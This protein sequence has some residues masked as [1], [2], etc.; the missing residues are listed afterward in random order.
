M[1]LKNII[2]GFL[3]NKE[4]NGETQLCEIMSK[5]GSD[6][7]KGNHNYTTLYTKIFSN[8]INEPINLFE[9]GLGTNNL[10]IDSNMGIDGKPGAS[11][12]GW[13]EFFPKGNI[14][15][16]DIDKRILFNSDRINTYYCDQC[17][18]D[19][20]KEMFNCCELKNVEFDI[21]IEDGLHKFDANYT[22]LTNSINRLK[23]GGIYVIEDLTE[24][25]IY[26]FNNILTILENKYSCRYISIV[27]IPSSHNKSDNNL[28]IC[29]V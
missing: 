22:F 23:K 17:S 25:T 7:G 18:P 26:K 3:I 12:F 1:D 24:E 27:K 2:E 19:L 6:K 11:L 28:L 9:L 16:A 20:I 4:Y 10:D 29:Q 5:Y 14:Y 8:L 21:I 13:R 15:G